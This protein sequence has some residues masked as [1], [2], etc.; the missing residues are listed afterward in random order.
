MSSQIIHPIQSLRGTLRVP[1]DKSISHRALILG[2]LCEGTV[3]I[4][5]LLDSEDVG[6]TKSILKQLGLSIDE[7]GG[8][9]KF[10]GLS[11]YG[12]KA[13]RERLYCGNSG[14]TLR[15]MTGLL[16]GQSFH[17]ELT[18]DTS[19]NRRP[20]GRVMSPLNEMGARISEQ[21]EGEERV[22]RI[23]GH[24]L[25]GIDYASPV[26]SAQVKSAILLAGLYAQSTVRIREPYPSRDH[27]ERMMGYL[28]ADIEWGPGW[29]TLETGCQLSAKEIIVPGDF[30][31]AAFFIV[32]ALLAPDS[33]IELESVLINPT[34]AV[35]IEV[36]KEMGGEI[37][38]INERELCGEPIADIKVKSSS[39]K[40]VELGPERIPQLIDE[41]PILS[42]AAAVAEGETVIRGAEELRVKETDRLK[43]VA[44]ELSRLG[45]SI[46]EFP[47]GLKIVGS[48]SLCGAQVKS[49]GDHRMAMALAVAGAIANDPV[50]IDDF[51]CVAVSYP[52]FLSDWKSL[53]GQ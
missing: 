29:V 27:T 43:A 47:D 40:G 22:I 37:Q 1:S 45:V 23:Q 41:I 49:Y 35:L 32:A 39:L 10:E 53:T 8:Q 21:R 6:R 33:E 28:G 46:E 42:V 2:A 36:L 30:S 11:L 12:L 18:G 52:N 5:N 9:L 34:R 24:N 26:A 13:P 51:N 15:L 7:E 44:S 19:L 17:T 3:T 20:M 48:D 38:V 16:A 31:S 25:S 14:T 50:T 4:Q